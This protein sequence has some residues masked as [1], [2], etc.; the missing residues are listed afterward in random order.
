VAVTCDQIGE[1]LT[2]ERRDVRW[3]RSAGRAEWVVG[4]VAEALCLLL[5]PTAL[6]DRIR[7]G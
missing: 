7:H 6:E 3:R 5:D 1:A 4:V 2:L